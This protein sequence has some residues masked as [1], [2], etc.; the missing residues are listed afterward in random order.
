MLIVRY[1]CSSALSASAAINGVLRGLLRVSSEFYAQCN[2][3]DAA[4]DDWQFR[5]RV[6]RARTKPVPRPR[7]RAGEPW[8]ALRRR[9]RA[10]LGRSEPLADHINIGPSPQL[11]PLGQR[12]AGLRAAQAVAQRTPANPPR[13][14]GCAARRRGFV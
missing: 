11:K 5:A 1:R 10:K 13:D 6:F 12:G 4:I 14:A 7:S 2:A 8:K 3:Q 9:R